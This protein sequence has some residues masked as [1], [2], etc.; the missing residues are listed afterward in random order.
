MYYC[1]TVVWSVIVAEH[2]IQA[3]VYRPNHILS[4]LPSKNYI[5]PLPAA[6]K[7]LKIYPSRTFFP[8]FPFAFILSFEYNLSLYL[9]IY[10]LIFQNFSYFLVPFFIFFPQMTLS[11]LLASPPPVWGRGRKICFFYIINLQQATN[12]TLLNFFWG[13]RVISYKRF[14]ILIFL[15][16]FTLPLSC[17]SHK[18]W[19]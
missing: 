9:S 3:S 13:G 17:M 12:E 14:C 4:P 7:Y 2:L 8:F 15:E 5:F 11:T 16:N 18:A 6:C 1:R 10:F 19:T